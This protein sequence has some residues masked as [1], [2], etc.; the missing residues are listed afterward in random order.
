MREE[1]KKRKPLFDKYED[2]DTF[3]LPNMAFAKALT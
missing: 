1:I 2:F 3:F